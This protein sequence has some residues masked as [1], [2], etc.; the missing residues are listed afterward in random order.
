MHMKEL[1]FSI[2]HRAAGEGGGL[3]GGGLTKGV[4]VMGCV[5][6]SCT[7]EHTACCPHSGCVP[8]LVTY[9]RLIM[10]VTYAPLVMSIIAFPQAG[11]FAGRLEV[12]LQEIG[13]RP[14]RL[15]V[16][17]LLKLDHTKCC[18]R[19]GDPPFVTCI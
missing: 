1:A 9:T 11:E 19:G 8:P 16:S 14:A 3:G 15:L 6:S 10:D 12:R 2:G 4:I 5:I 7:L 17:S 18:S 13:E